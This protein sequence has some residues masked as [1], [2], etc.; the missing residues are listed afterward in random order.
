MSSPRQTFRP[1]CYEIN[2]VQLHGCSFSPLSSLPSTLSSFIFI[3][4]LLV[5]L[6]S[7]TPLFSS[8]ILIKGNA[9]CSGLDESQFHR[10][11]WQA[12]ARWFTGED[13]KN[14]W[15]LD[16]RSLLSLAE[17]IGQYLQKNWYVR[18][19]S[20]CLWA[21]INKVTVRGR[22]QRAVELHEYFVWSGQH[23]CSSLG[24]LELGGEGRWREKPCYNCNRLDATL[25]NKHYWLVRGKCL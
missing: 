12:K 10:G 17:S 8:G 24:A 25:L 4:Y 7:S 19:W 3:Y 5:F 6:T 20:V 14:S 22:S 21:L 13:R 11:L 23:C 9:K 15:R 18:V 16:I 1:E 2:V